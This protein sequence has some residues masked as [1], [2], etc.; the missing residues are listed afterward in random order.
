MVS[1]MIAAIDWRALE[2]DGLLQVLRARARTPAPR[3]RRGTASGR[4]TGAQKCTTPA[5]GGVGG[6]A[7]RVAGEV[8]RGGGCRRGTSGRRTAP[9]RRPVCSRAMRTACSTASAP[10]LVKKILSR[11]PGVRSAISRAASERASTAKAGAN[12]RQLRGLLLDRGDD[13]RVLVA[14][15]GVDEP[16]G[17]VE[18]AVA[19]VVPEVRPLGAG[20]GERVDEL[21]RGPGVEDVRAV[22]GLHGGAGLR[23]RA[24][25]SCA[26]A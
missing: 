13:L 14:D 11:S 8:D 12:V 26:R 24:E 4:G 18:V 23:G 10:P 9:W 19:V 7:A 25:G 15:V 3:S 21:L 16:A 5:R 20:D 22:G 6:P 1:R 17:E 2:G